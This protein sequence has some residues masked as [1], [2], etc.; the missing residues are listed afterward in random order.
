[1]PRD[2]AERSP[3]NSIG[4]FP[5]RSSD[6]VEPTP[7]RKAERPSEPYLMYKTRVFNIAAQS[8]PP[9]Y[10]QVCPIPRR[11]TFSR[12]PRQRIFLT[13]VAVCWLQRLA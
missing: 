6:A 7:C 9:Y 2:E 3:E 1:M 4:F 8:H 13:E 5:W 12:V 10:A 11:L